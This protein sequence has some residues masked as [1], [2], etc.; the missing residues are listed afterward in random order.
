MITAYLK[1]TNFCNVGCSHCYLSETVRSDKTRMS[2][3]MLYATAKFLKDMSD[4]R[5]GEPVDIIWHGGEVLVLELEYFYR[6]GEI[7][8]EILG[9]HSEILQ[10]SLIPLKE[11]QIQLIKE[12][13]G[14]YV[15]SSIDFS[16]RR[17]KGST[18]KYLNLW[19]SKVEMAR[20]HG[21]H[22]IPSVVP[23]VLEID[24]A[25]EILLWMIQH[26]FSEF[27]IDRYNNF[28]FETG[29]YP[30]NRLHSLFLKNLFDAVFRQK[31]I[32]NQVPKIN[33]V[34]GGI[35][36]VLNG[37]SSERWGTTCQN[38]FI[39]IEPNGSLNSCPNRTTFEPSYSNILDGYE[40]FVKSKLRRKWIRVASFEHAGEYCR[41]CEFFS[42]CNSGCPINPQYE[43]GECSGYKSYLKHIQALAKDPIN[44]KMFQEYIQER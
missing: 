1:P 18:E 26:D 31:A 2:D 20:S 5:G 44:K 41:D 33:V 30:T 10:S 36:G 17:I 16:Q 19:L 23:T 22:I 25:E 15:G 34:E 35:L 29:E 43:D 38:D 13:M 11:S 28:G 42:W 3:E 37:I 32:G 8:D 4:D 21:I 39:V 40:A 24:V 9:E 7:F 6:A 27:N 14:G 12:R